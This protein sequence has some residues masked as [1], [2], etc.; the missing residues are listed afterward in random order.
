[1]LFS[2]ISTRPMSRR[3][4]KVIAMPRK[5]QI[6]KFKN[7]DEERAFWDTHDSTEY[8]DWAK[9]KRVTVSNQKSSTSFMRNDAGSNE[10]PSQ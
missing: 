4:K 9:G 6:P 5:K 8:I 10:T 1:M 2:V 7:E 3:D